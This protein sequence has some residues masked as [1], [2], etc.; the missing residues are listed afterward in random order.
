MRVT[1]NSI[2]TQDILTAERERVLEIEAACADLPNLDQ[3]KV[4]MIRCKAIEDGTPVSDVSGQL[5]HLLRASRATAPPIHSGHAPDTGAQGSSGPAILEAALLVRSGFGKL[6]EEQLGDRV[7]ESSR[8]LDGASFV[9]L[10][11]AGLQSEGKSIPTSSRNEMIRA[12]VSTYALPTALGNAMNRI[13]EKTYM[14]SPATWRSFCSVRSANDFK[15]HTS[16]RPS[17]T[18]PLEEVGADGELKHGGLKEATF[19]WS[20]STFGRMLTIPRQDIINDDLG[21]LDEVSPMMAKASLRKLADLVFSTL[22]AAPSSYFDASLGNLGTDAM[23]VPGLGAAIAAVRNQKDAE[24]NNLDI[25]P[26]TLLVSPDKESDAKIALDSEFTERVAE[27]TAGAVDEVRGTGN[28]QRQAVKLE[29]EPRLSNTTKFPTAD[30][31]DWYL[32]G[33]AEDVP[34]IV[35]FLDGQQAPTTEFFGLDHKVNSLAVSFRVYH[36]FGVALG[37]YRASYKSNVA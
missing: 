36:D 14:D 26:A 17:F 6:A 5:L 31:D 9:D 22:L 24:S 4:G 20:I 15:D 3:E 7:M 2:N 25:T 13:M 10:C 30:S 35:G 27:N 32:F 37:D 19:P 21:F 12:A 11:R 8:S 23:G 28:P 34:M 29:V 33:R 16:I 1:P 18:H